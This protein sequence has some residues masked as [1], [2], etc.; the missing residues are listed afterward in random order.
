MVMYTI[1]GRADCTF[2]DK[3]IAA[4]EEA[5]HRYAY[6]SIDNYQ[7]TKTLLLKAGLKTVPQI[8][9]NNGTLIGGYTELQEHLND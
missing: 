7:W 1:I 6:Y 9:E 5:G 3:A 8:F 2:C 4:I